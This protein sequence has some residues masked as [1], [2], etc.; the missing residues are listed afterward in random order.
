MEKAK[1]AEIKEKAEAFI[2]WIEELKENG[3][4]RDV[5]VNDFNDVQSLNA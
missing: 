2:A 5:I 1:K 4:A 3:V